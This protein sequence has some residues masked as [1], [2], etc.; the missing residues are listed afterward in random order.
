[1]RI[2]IIT[3]PTEKSPKGSPKN[4][5]VSPSSKYV[6]HR[7]NAVDHEAAASVRMRRDAPKP[8]ELFHQAMAY[9]QEPSSPSSSKAY[10]R[11]R[12]NA[13]GQKEAIAT[14]VKELIPKG[15]KKKQVTKPAKPASGKKNARK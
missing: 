13:V 10:N 1:M 9:A 11:V 6:P 2:Y 8:I 15:G 14:V 5:S 7:R 4:A 3:M 12:R